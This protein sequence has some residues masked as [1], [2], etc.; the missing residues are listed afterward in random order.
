MLGYVDLAIFASIL[1]RARSEATL[2]FTFKSILQF[3]Y[4]AEYLSNSFL[5]N[6][7]VIPVVMHCSS[8]PPSH[9]KLIVLTMAI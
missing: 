3:F 2:L 4:Q 6:F 5:D 8:P 7:R 9:A 1:C